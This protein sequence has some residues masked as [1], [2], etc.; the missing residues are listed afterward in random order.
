[1][2]IVKLALR[3]PYTFI[4]CA[5]VILL[6]S[7]LVILRTP[8][9]IFPEINIPVLSIVWNYSGLSA[10]EMEH[11]IVSGFER[12]L[13]TTVDNIEHVESQTVNGRSI[14]RV[15]FQPGADIDLA[16]AQATAISQTAVRGMPPGT[17]PPLIIRYSASTVPIMQ[18]GLRGEGLSEQQLNDLAVN[19]VRNRL[20]TIPGAAT[21]YPYGGKQRLIGVNVE[22]P[23]LQSKGLSPV[24][25]INAVSN[26]NL[27][28]PT[29][30]VKLG[31]IDYEVALNGTPTSIADLNDLPIKTVNGGTVYLRDVAT[32]SDSFS[33]QTNIVR[34]DGQRGVLLSVFKTG[35]ASTLQIVKQLYD[36]LPRVT[37]T[38]PPELRVLPMFDQSIFVRAAIQGVI[39]EALIAACLTATMILLFL[40]NWRST[41][42]IA[43]SIPLSI[44]CSIFTLS[45]LHET[46]NIMTLGGLALAVGILVDDATVEIEN[47]N[48]NLAMGKE[49]VH[50]ILD[51]ASQIAIP[52]FVSTL[53]ICIVFVP[54]FFL[55]G[56][57]KFLFV[58]LAEAVVF[59]M[60]ASYVL[61]RTL[62]PTL[63]MYLLKGHGGHE[64]ATGNHIFARGQRRF[65]RGFEKMRGSYRRSLR[66]CLE[67]AWTFIILFLILCLGSA[68]IAFV[69]GRDFFPNVDAGQ[70]RLHVRGRVAL[71][72]EETARLCDQIDAVIRNEIGQ[73]E[74][75]NI[76]DNIGLPYSSLNMSYSN[77]GTIGTSDAE[78]LIALKPEHKTPTA[79]YI[80]RLRTR[81]AEQFPSTQFFFQPADIVSQIL[82]FGVPAPMDIQLV[83]HD[84]DKT[85]P[86]AQQ[87][88]NEIQLIPGAAD[89]HVQQ[90]YAQPALFLDV[91]RTRAQSV[92]LSQNDVAQSL[93]L[94][95]S[96]SFQTAPSFWVD[97]RTGVTYNVA[98][99][100]PQY[101]VDSMQS[102]QNIPVSAA[103]HGEELLGNL[104]QVSITAHPAETRDYDAQPMIDIYAS[105]QGRDLGGVEDQIKKVIDEWRPKIPK[106]TEIVLRGQAETMESSFVGLA[107]GLI[108]AILL[109]YLL[110][111]V[112]FQSWVDP[113]IIITALPGALA[114]ILW[115]LLLT[116]TTLNVPSLTGT[117][118]CMGV[119][120]ANS[121]LMVTFARDQLR[122]GKN[123][124]E[125]ALEAGFIRIRPVIMTAMAMIIGMVPMALS[126]GEGGEQNAP[127]GRAVIGGLL[128]ATFAT[129]FF[130]PCVFKIVHRNYK[131]GA[132]PGEAAL[133]AEHDYELERKRAEEMKF[134]EM[135]QHDRETQRDIGE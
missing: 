109:V 7:P 77:T 71:R 63:A 76:L 54:M 101:K 37:A 96:S 35:G 91:D 62:V 126:L 108:V 123:S 99:Q 84:L 130:V 92:G 21:P 53:C 31:T 33:P 107:G 16:I 30:D 13:T 135:S 64:E 112:N 40:G 89:V 26:Q 46:M 32:V 28:L 105:V 15:Y 57:A 2:W 27:I 98:V 67:N 75:A 87:M 132:E 121:I 58:P 83:G 45:A 59:A 95:L 22:I 12:S 103:N 70:I 3:R 41:L 14:I 18:L 94:T 133:A 81:L 113:F 104:A 116:K 79:E 66:F 52:A 5:L 43:V 106:G 82:N 11:R 34:M 51:G 110:I 17:N 55:T 118:M 85:Y 80:S 19:F 56:V 122:E 125:A 4:V 48:R 10:I 88:A 42:I 29:G 9:D 134:E 44:L 20:A 120:T 124:L 36:L 68:P 72:I 61:S 90:L 86:L 23:A 129:L 102:L 111:V 60:L 39:R 25:V 50:A 73:D 1:M 128:F 78:I 117:I 38:L 97:P 131:P 100:V 74:V 93:L 47:I 8:T 49:T 119:G 115:M 24:D 127:L 69:L 6:L 65:V 114:G